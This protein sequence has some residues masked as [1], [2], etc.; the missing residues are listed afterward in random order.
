MQPELPSEDNT[1][2]MIVLRLVV[3]SMMVEVPPPSINFHYFMVAHAFRI[4]KINQEE[5]LRND[6]KLPREENNIF[7][8]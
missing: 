1:K 5:L 3:N 8:S 7:F 2:T 4:Y 6:Q